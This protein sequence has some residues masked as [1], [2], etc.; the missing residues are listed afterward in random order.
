MKDFGLIRVKNVGIG[1]VAVDKLGCMSLQRPLHMMLIDNN[2]LDAQLVMSTL[3]TVFPAPEFTVFHDSAQALSHLQ[4]GPEPL[5]DLLLMGL[6]LSPLTGLEVLAEVKGHGMLRLL[7]VLI[8]SSSVSPDELRACYAAHVTAVLDRPSSW[9]TLER[10]MLSL[11][12]FWTQWVRL[13][14]A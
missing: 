6:H 11:W 5:P 13:P 12:T 14:E 4:S 10:Q 9:I 7:P 3:E 1:S 8:L 2:A